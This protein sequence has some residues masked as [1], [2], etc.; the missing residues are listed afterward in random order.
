MSVDA[1]QGEGF[2]LSITCNAPAG[3]GAGLPV[4]VVTRGGRQSVSNNL[5]SFEAPTVT[6][7]EP[8]VVLTGTVSYNITITG[9]NLGIAAADLEWATVGQR[10]C[11]SVLFVSPEQ[12]ECVNVQA[13]W[14]DNNIVVQVAGQSSLAA[15]LL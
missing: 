14:Y 3:A 10:R 6:A 7:I 4:Q 8:S 13:P 5:F 11:E 12:V 2:P 15:E 9:T 1:S